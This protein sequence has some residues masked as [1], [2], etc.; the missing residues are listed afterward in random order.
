VSSACPSE[1]ELV[2]FHLGKLAESRLDSLAEHLEKCPACEAAVA[3]LERTGDPL[4]AV[5]LRP[6]PQVPTT[7]PPRERAAAYGDLMAPA[8]WPRL[9]GYE[10]LATLGRGGMG[11]VYKARQVRLNRLVALKLLPAG[12]DRA[13]GRSRAEAEALARFQHPNIV[14]VY[15]IVEHGEAT[16]LA[17]ELVEGG[18]LA[19]R[20]GK[21]QRAR[22]AAALVA[23]LA[24]A[25]H[26]AHARGVIHRDLKPENILIQPSETAGA[27]GVL[28][29]SDFGV[30]KRLSATAGETLEGDVVGTPNYMSP[31]QAS[32]K[33][34]P[35]GPPADV[36]SLGVILYEM[37]TG[38]VP[39]QG[40]TTLD[41]LA[42][43]RTEDPVPPRRL[44][45]SVG[46]DLNTICLKCLEKRPERR[47]TSAAALAEDLRRFLSDQPILARKPS[48]LYQF[49]KFSRRNKTLLGG[50][51]GVSVAVLL[52]L[53]FSLFFAF[54]EARQR[55][56]A[57][58][59]AR[60]AVREAYR[61][62][63]AAASA[64]LQNHDVAEAERQL[65]AAPEANRDWE[66]RH[67][68]SRL[69]ESS[70]V[71]RPAEGE[72][73]SLLPGPLGIRFASVGPAGSRIRDEDGKTVLVAPGGSCFVIHAGRTP[74]ETRLAGPEMPL[75]S[76]LDATGAQICR[77]PRTARIAF[78]PDLAKVALV[79]DAGPWGFFSTFDAKSGKELGVYD[80]K[81]GYVYALAYRPDGRQIASACEDG[82]ARLWD[83]TAP[84]QLAVLKGH[85]VKVFCVAYRPDGKRLLTSSADGTVCQWDPESG[86]QV[87]PPYE[88]H[89]GEVHVAAYSPDGELIA[90]SGT[91]GT[92]RIW[93]ATGRKDVAVYTGHTG[94]V[95]RLAFNRD[96]TRLA[97]AGTDGTVRVWEVNPRVTLPALR[98][99]TSYVYPVAYS[100]D[101]RWIASGSWDKTV[102]L[103]DARSGESRAVWA[104]PGR[105]LDLG[106]T[107]DG[108]RLVTACGDDG[109][110]RVR[111]VASGRVVREI[112][113][114]Q[115]S[116]FAL[117]LSPEGG[118]VAT[119]GDA[120]GDVVV[121]DLKT[122]EHARSFHTGGLSKLAY[123]PDG[124]L[125]AV[126]GENGVVYLWN[127]AAGRHEADL[128][129]HV[130]AVAS[131]SFGP[132]GRRLVS[133]GNDA[134]VRVWDI[135]TRNC[136]TVLRGHP[137]DIFSAVFHPGGT[138]VASAG[139]DGAVWLW[140]VE[141]GTE[142]ARL[143]GHTNYVWSLAF[144]PDGKSLASGSGDG[145]VRLWDTEPVAVRYRA[146]RRGA[147]VGG[148][149]E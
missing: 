79:E 70:A 108:S 149:T 20:L 132:D 57:V 95:Q 131:V 38:R 68:N 124:R 109:L 141:A 102:R 64:A 104:Y 83:A 59:N 97:S 50:V 115:K 121:V 144:S 100:P 118:S 17:L 91:D 135:A 84:K 113:S 89:T 123:S 106:F 28:K 128:E 116:V 133:A 73:L 51:V 32:G 146:L 148:S 53:A 145:T 99:H 139:R 12:S 5:L 35:V 114:G 127:V 98:G 117:A 62:R 6:V 129:G 10:I 92:V 140:D 42:L 39:I 112:A 76:I 103:W 125:L 60:E 90:S 16:F 96:G 33:K 119:I 143:Q 26:Y 49:H 41:T 37:L 2:A 11:V 44:Q 54:A 55:R 75:M 14:Q 23:E 18:T 29:I 8:N 34:E 105:V 71:F 4:L 56:A 87:E 88:R 40:P 136:Q 69:D 63:I 66:W 77:L 24:G 27:F 111:E 15:E 134:T 120:G 65:S 78:G 36:Y 107:P 31:E 3:R 67:L 85:S 21:P 30:A 47:Y 101:G 110:L 86:Q 72:S 22:E 81:C 43:V 74:R 94:I 80:G 93:K 48:L 45:P 58:E 46:R 82:T 122:G 13:Q 1:G 130:G 9:P 19:T 7:R 61:A 126:G 137:G 138:R 147:K 142:V 25:V 52:G